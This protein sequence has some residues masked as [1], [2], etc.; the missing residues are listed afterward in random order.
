MQVITVLNKIL[1]AHAGKRVNGRVASHRT[2]TAAGEA[3][4]ANFSRLH[5]LGYRLE[6]PRN[7]GERHITA[8][9]R[10]WHAR[11]LSPKTM[12]G[13]LSQ[14]RI[15]CGWIGKRGL[16]KDVHYYLPEVPKNKL[17]VE[18][19]TKKSKSWAENG[20]DVVE[21]AREAADL[22]KRFYLQI[23]LQV[24]FGLRRME[25]L[26]M[27]P[28][29][30]DQGDKFA[31][32]ETK[33]GRPRDIYIET[34]VQRA[35]LDYVKTQ[36][37]K[38]E[39]MGWV[40]RVDGKPFQGNYREASL[41]YS[42]NRYDYLMR[43]LGITK[44][45][46]ACTGHGLRAQFAENAALLKDLIPP[47]LGGTPGQM[48][49]ED[50]NVIR[51]QVSESLG[52]SRISVTGAYYGSFGREGAL[53][54]PSRAKDIISACMHNIDVEPMATIDHARMSQCIQLQ[55]ELYGIGIYDDLRKV[56][57][58]WMH[59]SR[60]HATEWL[61]PSSSSNLAALEAA[62][63]SIMRSVAHGGVDG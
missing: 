13:Y 47:T 29:K 37:K 21:K 31:V 2:T 44:A 46:T 1:N 55:A 32:Y 28:W 49:R 61:A 48:D 34:D 54:A 11:E 59:H 23:L 41:A 10:D 22:D 12:Q 50:M 57:V 58:L 33:G 38:K 52:H 36:V 17:R 5:E 40:E 25:V 27:V 53:D 6:D 30:V 9:C 45:M 20:V 4:R 26:Q 14:L 19:T 60:R 8:L 16:V 7:I 39:F 18:T 42:E 56:E 35:L 15:F 63:T 24:S 43:K 51:A 62:A 3:L